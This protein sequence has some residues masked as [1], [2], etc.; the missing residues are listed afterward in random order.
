[1]SIKTVIYDPK[2]LKGKEKS[3]K[4]LINEENAE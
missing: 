2:T 3:N 1:M 4:V